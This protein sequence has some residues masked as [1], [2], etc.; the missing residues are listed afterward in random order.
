MRLHTA[1]LFLSIVPSA[2]AQQAAPLPD[3]KT[4]FEHAKAATVIILAG[5]GAGRLHSL[6]TGVIISKDGVILTALHAIK[7]AAEVQVRMA[8]GDIFDRVDLLGS[9][10]RRDIAALKIAGRAL[11][12]IATGSDADLAQGD[13]VFAITNADGLSWSATEGILSAVRPADEIPGAGTGFRLLQFTAPVA[14]GSSGGALLD[15]TGSLIGI[16]TSGKDNAAFAVPV[17]NVLGLADSGHRV[18]LGS[19]AALQMPAQRNADVPQSSAALSGFD[20]K[21]ALKTARTVFIRSKTSF[22]TVDTL[23]RALAMQKDW[24]KLELAIVQDQRVADILI[25][26][27]RPLFTY[28]HTFVIVDKKTSVVLGSG[29]VTAFDGTIASPDIAK[30]IV[31]I[32]ATARLPEPEKAAAPSK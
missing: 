15:K 9:D 4:I 12:V 23:D 32:F 17:D 30:N 31:K 3:T 1:A 21:Q 24:P 13:S 2:F 5:E 6:A 28:V 29:K 26:I 20:P 16:I 7:G 8:N 14:H 11:P 27:D 22:L 25:E 10:E 19:G 18:T